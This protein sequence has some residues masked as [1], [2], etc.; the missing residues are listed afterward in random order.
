MAGLQYEELKVIDTRGHR[1]CSR[2]V[3][4]AG[5]QLAVDDRRG[6]FVRT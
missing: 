1:P 3:D 2:A 6:V 4:V 5:D